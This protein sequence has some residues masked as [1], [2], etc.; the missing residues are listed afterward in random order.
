MAAVSESPIVS[1]AELTVSPAAAVEPPIE[2][3]SASPVTLSSAVDR[4]N[5]P[6][7]D[8]PPAG[9]TRSKVSPPFGIE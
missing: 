7:F 3:A 4:V 8:D 5:V 2:R 6:D 1:D 9:I